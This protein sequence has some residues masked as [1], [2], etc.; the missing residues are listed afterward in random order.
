MTSLSLRCMWYWMP[1]RN[2]IH[3]IISEGGKEG[4]RESE[5]GQREREREIGVMF[6]II[7]NLLFYDRYY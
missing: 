1:S 6:I 2:S 7:M 3:R 4:E 5:E